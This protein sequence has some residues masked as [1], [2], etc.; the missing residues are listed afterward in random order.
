MRQK[1]KEIFEEWFNDFWGESFDEYKGN[2][3][4]QREAYQAAYSQGMKD[5]KDGK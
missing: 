2:H 4:L 5:A 3:R 1:D